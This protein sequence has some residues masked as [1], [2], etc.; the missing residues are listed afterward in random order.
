MLVWKCWLRVSRRLNRIAPV[1]TFYTPSNHD[2]GDWLSRI[3]IFVCMVQGDNKK[4]D[5][6]HGRL[7]PEVSAVW[8]HIRL[9]TPTAQPKEQMAQ[10]KR[11]HY[12]PQPCR[13]KQVNYGRKARFKEIHAAHL[14]SEQMIQEIN[15][16]IVRRISSPTA[17]DTW[18]TE[19]GYVG[20]VRKAQT[21]IYDKGAWIGSCYQYT[22]L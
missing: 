12:S 20:T 3:A 8:K 6:Q 22:C 1:K 15:G 19:S 11:H 21:F 17:L 7:S 10:K 9:G 2:E 18:H 4:R 5:N 16:V 14:H 13:M